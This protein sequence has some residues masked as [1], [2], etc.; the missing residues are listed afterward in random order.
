MRK[1]RELF[2][3]MHWEPAP[4]LVELVREGKSLAEWERK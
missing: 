3:P 4:L 1:Y 2:G